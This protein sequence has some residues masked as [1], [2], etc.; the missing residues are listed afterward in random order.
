MK[1]AHFAH[2]DRISL[3]KKALSLEIHLGCCSQ[4]LDYFLHAHISAQS[5]TVR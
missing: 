2:A 5:S 1:F 4:T 3:K